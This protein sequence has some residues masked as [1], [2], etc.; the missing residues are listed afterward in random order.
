MTDILRNLDQKEDQL[1][2][3]LNRIEMAED[4]APALQMPGIIKLMIL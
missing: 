3:E 1:I 4:L 2:T